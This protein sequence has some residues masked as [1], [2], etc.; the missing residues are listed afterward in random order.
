MLILE[1]FNHVFLI[2]IPGA[3]RTTLN[4]RWHRIWHHDDSTLCGIAGKAGIAFC[5][6]ACRCNAFG[7]AEW[8]YGSVKAFAAGSCYQRPYYAPPGAGR[9]YNAPA[10]TTPYQKAALRQ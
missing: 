1:S 3:S 6:R 9:Q 4:R 7:I 2:L 8:E 5:H 10:P